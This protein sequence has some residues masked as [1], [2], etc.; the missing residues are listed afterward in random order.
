MYSDILFLLGG[1]DLEMQTI[2]ELLKLH[3]VPFVDRKL[4][5]NTANLSAYQDVLD[6][7]SD[8]TKIYGI[9]LTENKE[10]RIPS[11]YVRIDHHNDYS[12]KSSSLEQVLDI[13]QIPTSRYFQLVAANDRGYILAMKEIGATDEEIQE[14]RQADRFAQGITFEEEDTAKKEIKYVCGTANNLLILKT[15]LSHFSPITDR[16]YPYERLLIYNDKKLCFY[17]D[18][19]KYLA[20]RYK[21]EI[22]EY[23]IYHG[24]GDSGYFGTVEGAFS[25]DEFLEIVNFIKNKYSPVLSP[26]SPYSYHIFYFPFRWDVNGFENDLLSNQLSLDNIHYLN[27]FWDRVQKVTDEGEAKLLYNEKN[28]YHPFVHNI[29]YD[30]EKNKT[31]LIRHFERRELKLSSNIYYLIKLKNREKP[32][33]L[34]VDAINLNLYATGVGFLSFYL[35]NEDITQSAPQD[36]LNINQFGR[37]IMPPFIKD[38]ESRYEIA[39]YIAIE[40]LATDKIYREDF[41]NYTAED[42]WKQASF[43]TLLISE[44]SDNIKITPIIDDRMYVAS[45]YRNDELASQFSSNDKAYYDSSNIFSSFWYKYLFVDSSVET[46][47]NNQMKEELLKKHSY[48]RWQKWGSLY[49]V[50]KYSFVYLANSSADDFLFKNFET[51]YARMIELVLVQRASML[52]FSSEVTNVSNFTN[53]NVDIISLKV[54]SL[55]KE[56]IKFVNQIYFREITVQDQGIELY[57]MFHDSLNMQAYITDLDGEIEE[58]HQYVSL[59][60]DQSRNKKAA[61]LNN[62]ATILL[63]VSVITGFWGMNKWEDVVDSPLFINQCILILIGLIIAICIIYNRRKK[64]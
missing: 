11:N 43:I 5:W 18:G 23:K 53:Q 61:F 36:I 6:K 45:W 38:I 20:E 37:R 35:V 48:L 58:L 9:E 41:K 49:G 10:V 60:E 27:S 56:Y 34:R 14:I 7:N 55:Y 62:I 1:S 25:D 13:L 29:L 46:C 33:R 57:S 51:I 24:G 19:V 17:G 28:Y 21:S 31:N 32:Y 47:Q 40:G 63:P 8:K 16:L 2:A 26:K 22:Q 12:S 39:E 54:S 64:L 44:L 42:S 30:E 4:Q 3:N 59:K 50:S 15:S 52:R